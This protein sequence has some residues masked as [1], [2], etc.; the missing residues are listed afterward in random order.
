MIHCIVD[1]KVVKILGGCEL[2]PA[3]GQ[4]GSHH[5][6]FLSMEQFEKWIEEDQFLEHAQFVGNRYGTPRIYVDKAMEQGRDAVLRPK[7]A[8][9][10]ILRSRDSAISR[11]TGAESGP[12]TAMRRPA[13]TMAPEQFE[14]WV[15]EDQ[16][17]EH[18]Q[19][20]GNRYGTPRLYVDKAMD[21]G[22]DGLPDIEIP[23][24]GLLSGRSARSARPGGSARRS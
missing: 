20:V 4:A 17:L 6:H 1:D 23:A 21:Q 19:F 16:F 12:T 5:Y 2:L 24:A 11:F 9:M 7:V 18:A 14:K 13:D 10:S 22:R 3:P 15:E 8:S